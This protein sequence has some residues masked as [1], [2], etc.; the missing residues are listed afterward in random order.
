[1]A[2]EIDRGLDGA[3]AADRAQACSSRSRIASGL[4]VL[5]SAATPAAA[6]GFADRLVAIADG[7]LVFDG[8]PAAFSGQRVAWRF[9][10]A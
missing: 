10:T 4:A 7:L 6:S 3:E 9:G 5:A 8:A 2:R 1:M